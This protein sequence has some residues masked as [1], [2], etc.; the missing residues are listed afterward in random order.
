MS[1]KQKA[2]Y[3]K[4]A[5]KFTDEL[6]KLEQKRDDDDWSMKQFQAYQK[7]NGGSA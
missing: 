6:S 5:D 2:K 7:S 1:A 3:D 4:K